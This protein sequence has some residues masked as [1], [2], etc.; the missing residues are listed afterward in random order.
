MCLSRI[1]EKF[2][3][4]KTTVSMTL[5]VTTMYVQHTSPWQMVLDL[6]ETSI[7]TC[8]RQD[9]QVANKEHAVRGL[10]AETRL[11]THVPPAV[12]VMWTEI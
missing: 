7:T 12:S 1:L 8:V 2:A 5:A 11:E 9:M 6:L 3:V 4:K 10:K